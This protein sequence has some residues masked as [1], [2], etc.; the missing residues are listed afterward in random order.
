MDSPVVIDGVPGN[1]H[2][3]FKLPMPPKQVKVKASKPKQTQKKPKKSKPAPISYAKESAVAYARCLLYPFNAPPCHIPDPDVAPSGAISS[4]KSI[5][6]APLAIS[7]TSTTHTF[8]FV[9]LPYP[10]NAFVVLQENV[11]GGGQVTDVGATGVFSSAVSVPN[12]ASLGSQG[13]RIRC[14]GAGIR[15]VYEGTELNR[16][17]RIF[18]GNLP[19][20]LAASSVGTSGT[21]LS[22]L[23]TFAGVNTVPV[24]AGTIRQSMS[25]CFEIRNPS[26]KV[27]EFLWKPS[28]TP[29]YQAYGPGA[30]TGTTAGAAVATS[31]YG[32]PAGGLGSEGGQNCL[33]VIVDGDVTPSATNTPNTYTVEAVWHWEVVPDDLQAVAY[34]LSP[35]FS[36]AP[37]LDMAFNTMARSPAGRALTGGTFNYDN[38]GVASG[39]ITQGWKQP[40]FSMGRPNRQ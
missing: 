8:G 4:H 6:S 17:G 5:T 31:V 7:G 24:A 10:Q 33:V 15:I 30:V 12:I 14:T 2:K 39:T 21:N 27:V 38:T 19:L 9:L 35:S 16:A 11:A 26:D 36:N 32:A 25:D 34:D 37:S 23:T 3:N 22:V 40:G 13:C 20:A 29:H 18:G 28:N 1:N